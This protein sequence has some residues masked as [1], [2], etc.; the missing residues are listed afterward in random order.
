MIP[1]PEHVLQPP[2]VCYGVVAVPRAI[3]TIMLGDILGAKQI[4]SYA[5]SL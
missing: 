5:H 2:N 4:A 3:I 1:I